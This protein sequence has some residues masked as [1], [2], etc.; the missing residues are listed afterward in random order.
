[1]SELGNLQKQEQGKSEFKGKLSK[2]GEYEVMTYAGNPPIVVVKFSL[3]APGWCR[4]QR[5]KQWCHLLEVLGE[6]QKER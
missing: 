1:M 6:A 4:L 3:S 5:S 2:G